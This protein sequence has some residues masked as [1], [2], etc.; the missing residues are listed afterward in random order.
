MTI[1]FADIAGF[2][3][4]SSSR[5]PDE[6]VVMLK[7]LF[8]EFDKMCLKYKLFKLYTIGDCYVILSFT[9]AAKRKPVEEAKNMVKMGLAMI[10]IIRE[11]RKIINF[12]KLDMRIGIHTVIIFIFNIIKF[13]YSKFLIKF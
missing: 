6:V 5:T 3:A 2:T 7:N 4:F 8:T 10:E 1:L 12:E 13:I 9:N 11:V